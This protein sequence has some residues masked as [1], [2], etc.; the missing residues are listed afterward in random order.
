MIALQ[1]LSAVQLFVESAW[2][3]I[4]KTREL[5]KNKFYSIK[6]NSFVVFISH[7]LQAR[8]LCFCPVLFLFIY[9]LVA[10]GPQS[11]GSGGPPRIF[12]DRGAVH[13]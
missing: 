3:R 7:P 5:S 12:G 13:A 2:N 9:L 1:L 10:L 4:M 6:Y 8:G 11:G